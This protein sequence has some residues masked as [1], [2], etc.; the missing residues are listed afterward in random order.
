M[1]NLFANFYLTTRFFLA[2]AGVML[3]FVL[4]YTNTGL[5]AVA[6]VVLLLLLLFTVADAAMVFGKQTQLKGNRIVGAVLSNGQETTIV[7]TLHNFSG[8][9]LTV[10]LLDEMPDQLQLRDFKINLQLKSAEQ[11]QYKQPFRPVQRGEYKFGNLYAFVS[12]VIGLVQ[13]RG[14]I[15]APQTIAVFPSIVEMRKHELKSF[16]RTTN[17]QGIKKLRR[18]GH[19]YEFEQIKNYV[20][21]DDYR[22]VNWKATGRRSDLMVNQ[23]EDEKAQSIYTI[24]DKSRV[25]K[26]PF[27]GLSLLDY[28]INTSLVLS[29]IAINRQDKAGLITFS[30]K[31]NTVLAA[32]RGKLQLHKILDA[33]YKEKERFVEA[34]YE[35]LYMAIRNKIKSRSLLVFFT[36][37]ESSY[38]LQRVLP[39]LRKI[40]Q[41]HLLVVVFFENT[42]VNSLAAPHQTPTIE[43]VYTQAIAQKYIYE[44]QQ[45]VWELK[46]YGIYSV[47]TKPQDLTVNTVNKYLELKSRGLI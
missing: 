14:V 42:E 9:R 24:I 37:F 19:S 46:Q 44:K 35:L 34:N 39:L 25:M 31:P 1:R 27:G 36:N 47:L 18:I 32:D 11:V 40:N 30:D 3:L 43:E 29:N 12:S 28:A 26:M 22:S 38:A 41:K 17:E 21:G 23:Y 45:L 33:L 20:Q 7:Y 4:G 6:V 16:N 10:Q 2:W 13:R 5:I 15:A 8:M